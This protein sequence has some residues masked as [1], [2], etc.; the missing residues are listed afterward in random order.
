MIHQRMKT[1]T[2]LFSGKKSRLPRLRQEGVELPPVRVTVRDAAIL[3]AV[4]QYRA[5]TTPQIEY[6]F[7]TTEEPKRKR[8]KISPRCQHRLQLLYHHGYLYR[9][10]QPQKLSEGRLPYVY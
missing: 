4:Y 1:M 9:D 7:F 2:R 6:L 3:A 8:E 5:L 10:E